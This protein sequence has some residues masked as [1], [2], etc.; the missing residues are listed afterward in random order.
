[1]KKPTQNREKNTNRD[2]SNLCYNVPYNKPILT[3]TYNVVNLTYVNVG[4]MKVKMTG[5]RPYN[6]AAIQCRLPCFQHSHI[7]VMLG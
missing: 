3:I 7:F 2:Y 4:K 5:K 6:V 1:M